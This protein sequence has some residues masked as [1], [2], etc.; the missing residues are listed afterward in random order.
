MFE[1]ILIKNAPTYVEHGLKI[2]FKFV[3]YTFR[4]SVF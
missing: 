1:L 4:K 3:K 2:Q